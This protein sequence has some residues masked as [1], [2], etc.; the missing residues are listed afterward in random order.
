M[1][2][3]GCLFLIV[4]I[5]QHLGSMPFLQSPSGR[6]VLLIDSQKAIFYCPECSYTAASD[7]SYPCVYIMFYPSQIHFGAS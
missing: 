6:T 3:N 5:T 4:L 7:N 2:L 1:S